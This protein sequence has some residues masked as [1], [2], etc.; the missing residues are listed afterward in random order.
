M[1]LV[2]VLIFFMCI[3][4]VNAQVVESPSVP[5]A[6]D[7]L[8][9]EVVSSLV[10]GINRGLSRTSLAHIEIRRCTQSNFLQLVAWRASAA[11]PTIA[12]TLRRF[13]I[14]QMV[15]NNNVA[16]IVFPGGYDVIIVIEYLHGEPRIAF[17]DSTHS[18][19]CITGDDKRIS[20]TVDDGIENGKMVRSFPVSFE[21]LVPRVAPALSH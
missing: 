19:I 21:D 11:N 1:K 18:A 2:S 10:L 5:A 16:A 13:S 12:L 6:H 8:C 3:F 9:E 20:I 14:G 7:A 4:P 17:Y 15:L